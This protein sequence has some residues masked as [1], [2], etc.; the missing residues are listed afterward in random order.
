MKVQGIKNSLLRTQVLLYKEESHKVKVSFFFFFFCQSFFPIFLDEIPSSSYTYRTIEL[1][2]DFLPPNKCD[3]RFKITSITWKRKI[4]FF[5]FFK[6]LY[7]RYKTLS[8]FFS[9]FIS[10]ITKI[11]LLIEL[12]KKTNEDLEARKNSK[13]TATIE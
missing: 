13:I 11:Y 2:Y 3:T 12:K 4:L 6:S 5:F 10:Q 1:F 9:N 8:L 7:K